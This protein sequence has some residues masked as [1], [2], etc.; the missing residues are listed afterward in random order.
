MIILVASFIG[1]VTLGILIVVI[2]VFCKKNK[3]TDEMKNLLDKN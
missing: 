1:V 2:F 3:K